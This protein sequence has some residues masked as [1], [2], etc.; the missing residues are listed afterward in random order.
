[1]DKIKVTYLTSA[2]FLKKIDNYEG[3]LVIKKVLP[4]KMELKYLKY[5][6]Q[7]KNENT[8]IFII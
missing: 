3:N 6:E 1:M 8:I 4:M 2:E 7:R 5:L